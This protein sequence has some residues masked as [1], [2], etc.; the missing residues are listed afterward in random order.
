MERL[1]LDAPAAVGRIDVL[2]D[3]VVVRLKRGPD[4]EFIANCQALL[5]DGESIEEDGQTVAVTLPVRA[6]FRSGSAA[7][8]EQA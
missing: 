6:K 2:V 4:R 5:A 8:R 7:V 1:G 3:S